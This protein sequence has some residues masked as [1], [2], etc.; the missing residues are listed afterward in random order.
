MRPLALH[1]FRLFGN[2]RN[3]SRTLCQLF[4]FGAFLAR[5]CQQS[6]YFHLTVFRLVAPLT[7]RNYPAWMRINFL[8]V[9]L[10][11]QYRIIDPQKRG[12]RFLPA[13]S[14]NWQKFT[15]LLM[16][17]HWGGLEACAD[18]VRLP[19]FSRKSQ[20]CF[21][22]RSDTASAAAHFDAVSPVIRRAARLRLK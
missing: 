14:G 6:P 9:P 19:D 5:P 21:L 11:R 17:F 16:H 2:R 3:C 12:Q 20:A 4:K 1:R 8:S 7:D 13:S 10:C 22:N 15:F 18:G